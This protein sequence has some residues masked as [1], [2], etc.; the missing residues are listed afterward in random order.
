MSDDDVHAWEQVS[1]LRDLLRQEGFLPFPLLLHTCKRI[2]PVSPWDLL[3]Y[4]CVFMVS[5]AAPELAFIQ[6]L[7]Q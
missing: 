7:G 3:A 4:G 1:R 5:S 2:D 6:H